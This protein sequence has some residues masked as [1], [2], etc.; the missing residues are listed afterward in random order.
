MTDL[1]VPGIPGSVNRYYVCSE[2]LRRRG[3]QGVGNY[4][5]T[6][7]GAQGPGTFEHALRATGIGQFYDWEVAKELT[8]ELWE[9]F[10]TRVKP[11]FDALREATE[12]LAEA[13]ESEASP[14]PPVHPAK[15]RRA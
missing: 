13:T 10:K 14:S 7:G 4:W 1:Y 8:V 9:E 2:R 11:K 15:E 3:W 6:P 12:R 5:W